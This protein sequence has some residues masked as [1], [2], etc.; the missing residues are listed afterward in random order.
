MIF[1]FNN[2]NRVRT[3][4]LMKADAFENG[5]KRAFFENAS[6]WKCSSSYVDR[7]KRSLVRKRHIV[8]FP[9]ALSGVLAWTIGENASKR[10]RFQFGQTGE[11]KAKSGLGLNILHRFDWD[12]NEYILY[13]LKR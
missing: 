4:T 13:F 10:L 3:E 2:T 7:W 12:E 1:S 6:F 8:S 11:N 5:F 9:S